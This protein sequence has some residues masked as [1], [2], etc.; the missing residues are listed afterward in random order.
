[1]RVLALGLFLLIGLLLGVVFTN[2]LITTAN[3]GT[4]N[5]A[6]RYDSNQNDHIEK[7]EALD[8]VLDYFA[9]SITRNQAI[10]VSRLWY[11]DEAVSA[12]TPTPT[13]TPIAT[14]TPEP[15][16]AVS[17]TPEVPS[18]PV[19]MLDCPTRIDGVMRGGVR[20][21]TEV[22][23]NFEA[24][25]IMNPTSPSPPV[26]PWWF[27]VTIREGQLGAF[28][29]RITRDGEWVLLQ[30]EGRLQNEPEI[31]ATG[32][33]A[34]DNI[35]FNTGE[36]ARNHITFLKTESFQPFFVNGVRVPVTIFFARGGPNISSDDRYL[37]GRR[38]SIQTSLGFM[39]FENQCAVNSWRDE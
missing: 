20:V 25:F 24:T 21:V 4:G 34:D 23:R 13:A 32:Y 26:T 11:W 17:P 38:Y 7:D 1:M 10:Q 22:S 28:N 27:G 8:A 12:P 39:N 18:E 16:I 2:G 33:L 19:L 6:G 36:G 35:P 37:K 9:E 5:F 29:L 3:Q 31:Q 14:L 30:T 15:T